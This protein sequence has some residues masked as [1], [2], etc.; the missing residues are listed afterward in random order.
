EIV[1]W[2]T[3][4]D[5]EERPADARAMLDQ[6]LDAH[7]SL[8]TALSGIGSDTGHQTQIFTSPGRRL[9]TGETS[10]LMPAQPT[11]ETTVIAGG[12]GPRRARAA[13]AATGPQLSANTAALH[14]RT[15]KRRGRGW[16]ALILVLLL[17]AGGGAAGWWFS[18]GPGA[19]VAVPS[20]LTNLS[21][22]AA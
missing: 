16:I 22:E 10:V 11:A 15:R 14:L 2:A 12:N 5:P 17:A 3:A 18:I 20:G 7:G 1:Q 19:Q 21:P 9:P 4:R 6:V 13:A 8:A